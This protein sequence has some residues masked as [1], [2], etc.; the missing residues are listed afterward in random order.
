MLKQMNITNSLQTSYKQLENEK[1]YYILKKQ[2]QGNL[3]Q[4]TGGQ[5]TLSWFEMNLNKWVEECSRNEGKTCQDWHD[6]FH[7]TLK[8]I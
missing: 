4:L 2:P 8:N 3:I 5:E 7:L 6:Q 1:Y